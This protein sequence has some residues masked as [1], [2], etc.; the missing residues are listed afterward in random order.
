VVFCHQATVQKGTVAFLNQSQKQESTMP[1]NHRK[2]FNKS[3]PRTSWEPVADW[4]AGWVGKDG[5]KHHRK[6]AIPIVLELLDL[7]PGIKVLEVGAGH[8]VL[9]PHVAEAGAKYTGVDVSEKLLRL[10][11]KYHGRQGK[12][13]LGDA[14]RLSKLSQLHPA[15][16]DA[17]VFMLSLQDM[18]SLQAVL[19]SASWALKPGGCL[20]LLMTHPC[21]RVPRQSGWGWDE[22]RKL[23]YRRVD[24][25]LTPLR[26]PMHAY[27]GRKE[28]VT[29]SF[30]RPLSEYINC[31]A[32]CGLLLEQ[33]KEI[34]TYKV[35]PAETR[36]KAKNSANQEIPLFLGLRARKTG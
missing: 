34:P 3:P 13:I 9:A 6:L 7:Q 4:Y 19:K 30:H 32:A 14:R 24:R 26:V 8:G 29:L 10:A 27:P 17:V 23:Q 2:Q 11:R 5:S 25:Y 21:F 31:L 15:E 20:V 1:K 16:F 33:M 22:Q 35:H 12:F 28:G 18:E 36:A